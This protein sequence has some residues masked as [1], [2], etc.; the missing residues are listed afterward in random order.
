MYSDV[1]YTESEVVFRK[2]YGI[3]EGLKITY[4]ELSNAASCQQNETG[5]NVVTDFILPVKVKGKI[6]VSLIKEDNTPEKNSDNNTQVTAAETGTVTLDNFN[7]VSTFNCPEPGCVKVYASY[8]ALENHVL[9]GVHDVRLQ[10][11]SVYDFIKKK[12]ADLC[13]SVI[14][15]QKGSTNMESSCTVM[16]DTEVLPMGWALK[17]VRKV[18]RFPIKIKQFLIEK[19]AEGEESGKKCNPDDVASEMKRLRDSDGNRVFLISECLNSNQIASFFSRLVMSSKKFNKSEVE[20]E[21]LLAAA[22]EIDQSALLSSVQ[23]AH[24]Y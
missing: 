15:L 12:G 7:G 21:D 5:C 10:K 24:V 11:E 4:E 3:G 19:F 23:V 18:K 17:K 1:Q 2:A 13:N 14:I 9:V 16:A 20:D 22:A 6:N 8:R